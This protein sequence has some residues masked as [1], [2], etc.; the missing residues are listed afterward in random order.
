MSLNSIKG[1][2]ST[3]NKEIKADTYFGLEP[4]FPS[5]ESLKVRDNMG[6]QAA[7]EMLAASRWKE[8]YHDG[9]EQ[10]CNMSIVQTI[11][12][13]VFESSSYTCDDSF[14]LRCQSGK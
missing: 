13:Y 8:R 2:R 10:F 9:R 5:Q 12:L 11:H 1:Y 3:S 14:M 7:L 6:F 4:S